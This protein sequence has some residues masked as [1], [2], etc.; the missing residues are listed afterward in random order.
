[1]SV[2]T[3]LGQMNYPLSARHINRF[4]G[5]ESDLGQ[6][7]FPLSYNAHRVFD[8]FTGDTIDTFAWALGT[9]GGGA[10]AFAQ[11]VGDA[12]GTYIRGQTA[13]T[14]NNV[15]EIN[16]A[17]HW[18]GDN[19]CLFVAKLKVDRSP[20]TSNLWLEF[21]LADA[22]TDNTL[23]V[24]TDSDI[25]TVANGASN[26][27]VIALD[28]DAVIKTARFVTDGGTAGMNAAATTLSPVWQPTADTLFW[29][30]VGVQGD[31]AY[32]AVANDSGTIVAHA[33]HGSTLASRIEGGTGLLPRVMCGTRVATDTIYDIDLIDVIGGDGV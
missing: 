4:T 22:L 1:M 14:D 3:K 24:V 20:A 13:A 21:G 12:T 33:E 18:F 5:R 8:H 7:L 27:A 15:V 16:G 6:F 30:V 26:A 17:A 2:L 31:Y 25:P 19:H 11:R 29:V 28:G 9:D 23:P 32:G 10:T